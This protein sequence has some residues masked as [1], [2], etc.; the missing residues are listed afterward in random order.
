MFD[1]YELLIINILG[2]VLTCLNLGYSL[3]TAVKRQQK[4]YLGDAAAAKRIILP[5][6]KPLMKGFLV[7]YGIAAILLSFMFLEPED[8]SMRKLN[9]YFG[10]MMISLFSIIPVLLTHKSI[11]WKSFYMTFYT[12][13]PWWIVCTLLWCLTFLSDRDAALAFSI[14][15]IIFSTLFPIFFAL[16]VLTKFISSRIQI[17]S[18][19]NRNATELFLIYALIYGIT[20]LTSLIQGNTQYYTDL[21]LTILSFIIN[22]L[23]PYAVY[24]TLLADTKFWRGMGKHNQGGIHVHDDLRNSGIEVHRPT[25]E[26]TMINSSFQTMMADI[27]DIAVDFA[28][29]QLE[30]LIGQGATSKVFRGKLKGKLAAIKLST[31]PEIT[32]EVIDVFV[33]EAKVASELQH[34]NIVAFLGICVRPPQICMIFEFCDGGNLKSNLSHNA[35]RWTSI[36]RLQACID[37]TRAI[38]YLHEHNFIHRDIKVSL[39]ASFSSSYHI[40][41]SPFF[42]CNC[43]YRQKISL[44]VKRISSN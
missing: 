25:M 40:A 19:S 29:L 31:P 18:R 2:C 15:Y 6:F 4:A 44:W 26:L 8:F 1:Q 22:Q 10:F 21:V 35:L 39:F 41:Y 36:L 33:S 23:F 43:I 9:Q 12:V 20:Y 5:C 3:Y 28:Y 27:D 42:H 14:V 37:A 24:R 30:Q 38:V 11:S 7:C 17:G 13:S 16:L 34:K 32:E